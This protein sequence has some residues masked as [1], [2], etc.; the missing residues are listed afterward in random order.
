M[1][2]V[3]A[4]DTAALHFAHNFDLYVGRQR[5]RADAPAVK[6]REQMHAQRLIFRPDQQPHP[7]MFHQKCYA[8][9]LMN[10]ACRD[11]GD[12]QMILSCK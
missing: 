1:D 8:S 7:R 3:R 9:V 4:L 11:N 5:S 10:N 2:S 12:I 6:H